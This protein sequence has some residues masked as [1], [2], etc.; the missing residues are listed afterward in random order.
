MSAPLESF[1]YHV[2]DDPQAGSAA[3]ARSA[4]SFA[5]QPAAEADGEPQTPR[6]TSNEA[7]ARYF[8]DELLR[9]D[10]RPAMRVMAA[11]AMALTLMP[12]PAPAVARLRVSPITPIFEAE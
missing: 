7:A 6:F 5:A 3:R 9:R 2:A 12:C 4:Q 10:D 8:L 11:G 1:H